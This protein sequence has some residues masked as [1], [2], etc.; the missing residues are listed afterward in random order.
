MAA[1]A[2]IKSTCSQLPLQNHV[3]PGMT[4]PG[5]CPHLQPHAC[6]G[7]RRIPDVPPFIGKTGTNL[8][9]MT[10]DWL[11]WLN[12]RKQAKLSVTGHLTV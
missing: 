11:P 10:N 2:A 3:N 9:I 1:S 7:V 5:D 4:A 8:R 6:R 12:L